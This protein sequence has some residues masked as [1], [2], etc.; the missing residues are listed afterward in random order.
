MGWANARAGSTN[1]AGRAEGSLGTGRD[2]MEGILMGS[3]DESS[4]GWFR[5]GGQLPD[6]KHSEGNP[7]ET[8]VG[9]Y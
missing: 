7:C 3:A 8:N 4:M 2:A 1:E 9:R 5:A 6:A